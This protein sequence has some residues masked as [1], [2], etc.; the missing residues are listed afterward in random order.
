[1]NK[2]LINPDK[3]FDDMEDEIE[4]N[5]VIEPPKEKFFK[6]SHIHHVDI[7]T[8]AILRHDFRN[9]LLDI[10]EVIGIDGNRYSAVKRFIDSAIDEA[11]S[12][13]I[14]DLELIKED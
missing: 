1:M 12:Q 6:E 14:R 13:I 5:E 9:K 7:L 3:S 4:G 10:I 8:H 2:Q 11:Q